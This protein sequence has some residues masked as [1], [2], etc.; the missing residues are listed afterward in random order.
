MTSVHITVM[1]FRLNKPWKH[2]QQT[3]KTSRTTIDTE[4]FTRQL[5]CM[6]F[7]KERREEIRPKKFTVQL[8]LQCRQCQLFLWCWRRRKPITSFLFI[9]LSQ[10][11]LFEC[12]VFPNPAKNS[13]W[14]DVQWS[15]R[16]P[17]S[18]F[19]ADVETL[20]DISGPTSVSS[21]IPPNPQ[22][23]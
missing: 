16:L 23:F 7:V 17:Y 19:L 22:N 11:A 20:D 15:N 12:A 14:W 10:I 8:D 4:W 3:E 6:G 21:D 18:S 5:R 9:W 13:L 1:T 2:D